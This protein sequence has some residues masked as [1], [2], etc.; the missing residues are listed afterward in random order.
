[1]IMSRSK[2]WI[3]LIQSV[4]TFRNPHLLRT[5]FFTRIEVRKPEKGF[6]INDLCKWLVKKIIPIKKGVM[7][8]SVADDET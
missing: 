8:P 1:M 3:K 5:V 6:Y 2:V 4:I 7:T